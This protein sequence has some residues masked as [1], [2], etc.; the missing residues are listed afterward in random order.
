MRRAESVPLGRIVKRLPMKGTWFA[1][2]Y[3]G[4]A[5]LYVVR[6]VG[7]SEDPLMFQVCR[8]TEEASSTG[9]VAI[10]PKSKDISEPFMTY[11]GA[12][13]FARR[14]AEGAPRGERFA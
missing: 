6:A 4:P 8:L 5:G 7:F 2:A 11:E 3:Q 1:P 9:D 10:V 14:L 12:D 13:Q